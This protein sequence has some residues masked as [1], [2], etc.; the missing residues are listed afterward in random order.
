M[1]SRIKQSWVLIHPS[2]AV[3][4]WTCH[5][6]SLPPISDTNRGEENSYFAISLKEIICVRGLTTWYTYSKKYLPFLLETSQFKFYFLF[7]LPLLLLRL[8]SEENKLCKGKA[9]KSSGKI[10]KWQNHWDFSK[11]LSDFL[12][13]TSVLQ[14]QI[15][16]CQTDYL[17]LTSGFLTCEL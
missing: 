16:V 2:L 5:L 1:G 12:S 11:P 4:S 9:M 6:S 14:I 7:S 10:R 3:C 15:S 8:N 17:L 13:V